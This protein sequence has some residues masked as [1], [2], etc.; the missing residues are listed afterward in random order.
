VDSRPP[1]KSQF[2]VHQED[3]PEEVN[4]L[5]GAG[6]NLIAPTSHQSTN[7]DSIEVRADSSRNLLAKKVHY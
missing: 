6:D 4:E 3:L 7:A 2:Y 5:S 1:E